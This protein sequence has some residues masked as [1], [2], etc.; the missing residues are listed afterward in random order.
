MLHKRLAWFVAA[1]FCSCTVRAAEEKPHTVQNVQLEQIVPRESISMIWSHASLTVG[2]DGLVYLAGN[3]IVKDTGFLLRLTVD[4]KEKFGKAITYANGNATANADGV[5][6]SS[7]GHFAH[8]VVTYSKALDQ[9]GELKDFQVG[10]NVGWDAPAR[11]EAGES[12][13]FY[14]LDQHRNRIVRISPNGQETH[15]YSIPRDP[16]DGNATPQD[17]RVLDK[18]QLFYVVTRGGQ[19]RCLGFDGAVKWSHGCGGAWDVDSD[20]AVYILAN[21]AAKI[22][23]LSPDGKPLADIALQMGEHLP[24]GDKPWF[25]AL[26]LAGA[27]VLLRTPSDNEIFQC[28][29]LKSGA[30][31]QTINIDQDKLTVTFPSLVWTAGQSIP[32][33]IHFDPFQKPTKPVWH[34]WAR[35]FDA[36]D[37]HELKV[38]DDKPRC[39]RQHG[40]PLSASK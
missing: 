11:V 17:L 10:D 19:M 12:G 16:K 34:V 27:N 13:D 4:G 39:S 30:F 21:R 25:H 22:N 31:V 29:D 1:W 20:G 36:V 14:G 6:A 2:R 38:V 26:R 33:T 24:A 18:K 40:G 23:V 3:G 8:K 15:A 5:V 32:F 37:Y 35:P 7:H 9:T 28:Y